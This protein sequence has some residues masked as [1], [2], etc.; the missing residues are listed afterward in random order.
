MKEENKN[1]KTVLFILISFVAL[2]A[3]ISGLLL[4]SKPDGSIIHLPLFLLQ[5]T[6]FK[7]FLIPGIIL[8][9]IV[10]GANLL[11][12]VYNIRRHISRYNWAIAGGIMVGGWT[13]VQILLIQS[14]DWLH[15]LYLGIGSLI[16][17]LAYQLN[18]KWAV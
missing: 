6:P 15:F 8:T 11:A 1:M 13:V 7:N 10:G 12:V 17:L 9:T 16:I 4:I 3:T 5:T 18:G 14:A 2:T